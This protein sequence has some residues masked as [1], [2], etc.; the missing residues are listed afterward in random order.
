VKWG[1]DTDTIVQVPGVNDVHPASQT[2][3]DP[4]MCADDMKTRCA[5]APNMPRVFIQPHLHAYL[6]KLGLR[7]TKATYHICT[8]HLLHSASEAHQP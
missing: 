3:S 1:R 2:L 6:Y 7:D 5:V 8:P 4:C